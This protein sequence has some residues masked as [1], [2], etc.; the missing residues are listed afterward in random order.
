MRRPIRLT[1]LFVTGAILVAACG[2]SGGGGGGSSASPAGSAAASSASSQPSPAAS[3]ATSQDPGASDAASAEPSTGSG[4]G[5]GTAADACALL[6]TD[7]VASTIGVASTTSELGPGEPSYC[8]Y[9]TAD[10]IAAAVSLARVNGLV[11]FQV[12]E[13]EEG[14]IVKPGIG[15]KAIFSPSTE[16]LFI[17]KGNVVVGITAGEGSAGAA[18]RE[19]WSTALGQLADDRM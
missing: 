13:A 7:E 1:F 12:F 8:T 11:G 17:R 16:T 9:R 18:Q 19:E 10:D 2:S 14:A 5:G 4:G 15:D 6:T 3:A